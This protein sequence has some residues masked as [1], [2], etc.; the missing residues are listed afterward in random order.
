VMMSIDV[1][2]PEDGHTEA[3]TKEINAAAVAAIQRVGPFCTEVEEDVKS[4]VAAM[5]G[6][7]VSSCLEMRTWS[8]NDPLEL[9]APVTWDMTL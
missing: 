8:R 7:H 9:H 6:I 2:I 5:S 1:H 3:K 4:S